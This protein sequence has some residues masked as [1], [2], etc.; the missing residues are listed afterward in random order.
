MNDDP[1]MSLNSV[2]R[3]AVGAKA[4]FKRKITSE[5]IQRFVELTGDDNPLHVNEAYA[6]GSP[7][8]GIVAHGMLS[9]SYISTMVG[10]HLPGRGALWLS[11][12][13]DF[14]HPVRV[15]DTLSIK[16]EVFAVHVAQSI[17][18]INVSV[19]NQNGTDVLKGKCKVKCLEEETNLNIEA[20]RE[21]EVPVAIVTG[22][23]RGIGAATAAL[24]AAQGYSVVVNYKSDDYGARQVVADIEKAG[25]K[26]A[27]I[28]ADITDEQQVQTLIDSTLEYFGSISS[29]V[30]NA[31]SPLIY[32]PINSLTAIDVE[33]AMRTNFWGPFYIIKKA[34][35]YLEKSANAA[36]VNLATINTDSAPAAQLS[37]YT[38]SKA[39]LISLT[40]SLAVE[41]GPKGIRFNIVSPGMTDTR[42]IG[43]TPERARMVTKMQT[44]LRRLASPDDIA[45]GVAFLLSR[46]AKH[47]T[48]ETLRI[49]GGAVMI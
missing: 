38:C 43:E 29:I 17:L 20:P 14:L 21:T 37:A 22:A 39:A 6:R 34:L 19:T 48:G 35:P 1:R 31:T 27:A 7:F 36:V 24:L 41:L 46:G 10:K 2:E 9:A 23:S 40:K 18:E 11:Q 5:N 3:F 32:K 33:S 26:A 13:L 12:S 15:G 49:C 30:N 44:P 42:L 47:I 45:N 16:A 25:G 4:E 28:R 8:K